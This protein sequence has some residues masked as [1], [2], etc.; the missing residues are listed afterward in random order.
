MR[1]L[2]YSIAIGCMHVRSEPRPSLSFRWVPKFSERG[3]IF[4]HEAREQDGYRIYAEAKPA[5]SLV[6]VLGAELVSETLL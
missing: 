6:V 4:R 2:P 1:E 5:S 3:A